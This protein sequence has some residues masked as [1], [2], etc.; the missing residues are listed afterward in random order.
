Q[1]RQHRAG[2]GERGRQRHAAR[3]RGL[4]RLRSGAV[5]PGAL[6]LVAL[7]A[8]ACARAG[9]SPELLAARAPGASPSDALALGQALPAAKLDAASLGPLRTAAASP[10]P[11]QTAALDALLAAQ[12]RLDE[13]LLVPA[14]LAAHP[15]LRAGSP[16][17]QERALLLRGLEAQRTGA[18][19]EAETVLR[20][21]P[22]ASPLA[23]RARYA[24][25]IVL[26]DPR[27][28]GG[29][30]MQAALDELQAVLGYG[31]GGREGAETRALAQLAIA[32]LLYGQRHDA[33][34]AAA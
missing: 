7:G 6:L 5:R 3:G 27:H 1:R 30:R 24:L 16:E 31:G 21:T 26:S 25:G 28:P 29:P 8:L 12:T 32:R 34:S 15:D 33:A 23:P 4:P 18:L 10:G 22:P 2:E 20:R 13:Q 14:F 19:Q 11:S 17:L 9:R